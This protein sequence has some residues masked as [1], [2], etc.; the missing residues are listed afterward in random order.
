MIACV[1]HSYFVGKGYSRLLGDFT[2]AAT[3]VTPLPQH[4][5]DNI[6]AD[7]TI[8]TADQG[9]IIIHEEDLSCYTEIIGFWSVTGGT[10]GASGG[11]TTRGTGARGALTVGWSSTMLDRWS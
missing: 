4:A 7:L 10:L 2:V 6:Y 9:T 5:C 1:T 11:G 3:V 8:T